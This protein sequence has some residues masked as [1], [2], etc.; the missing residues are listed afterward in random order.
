MDELAD[1]FQEVPGDLPLLTLIDQPI[2]GTFTTPPRNVNSSAGKINHTISGASPSNPITLTLEA[3]AE[4]NGNVWRHVTTSVI[5]A[6][7][8]ISPIAGRPSGQC[9]LPAWAQRFR[10]RIIVPNLTLIILDEP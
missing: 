7:A 6:L 8:S 3:S 5:T 4:N 9:P 10:Y 1:D 2:Q